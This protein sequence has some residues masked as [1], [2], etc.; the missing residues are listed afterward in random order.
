MPGEQRNDAV[1]I[2]LVVCGVGFELML[3]GLGGMDRVL[4]RVYLE[5]GQ[6]EARLRALQRRLVRPRVDHEK[7]RAFCHVLV[8]GI[9]SSTIGPLTCGAT[10]TTLARTYASSVRG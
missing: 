7:Q 4:K 9:G 5:I 1:E 2:L 3:G 10:P 8:I 6:R